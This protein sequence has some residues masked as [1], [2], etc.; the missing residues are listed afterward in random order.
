[1]RRLALL[2]AVAPLLAPAGIARAV[3]PRAVISGPTT[4]TVGAPILLDLG[5]SASDPAFPLQVEVATADEFKPALRVWFDAAQQPG[6]A[7]FTAP[8]S[9]SY[10][11]VVVAI[12]TPAGADKPATRVA[13]WPLAIAPFKPDPLPPAP[14]GPT[15]PTPDPL[16]P[17]PPVAGKVWGVLIV[18]AS[19]SFAQAALRTSAAIR[20]AFAAT[21]DT[22]LSSYLDG[23][24]EVASAK[25]RQ[26]IVAAGPLPVVLWIDEAGKVIRATAPATEPAI[27]G[28]LKAIRGG[29]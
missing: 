6:L 21:K 28:D 3:E 7:V 8:R 4:G 14:P 15:P 29:P 20:A 9:G 22:Y 13:A 11:V 19:P 1:M 2:A 26:A 24:A 23:E 10:T 16:P 25:W 5:G 17:A 18:P 12:G 27:L